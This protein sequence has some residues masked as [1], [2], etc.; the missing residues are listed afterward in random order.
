MDLRN[1]LKLPAAFRCTVTPH[2]LFPKEV[3]QGVADAGASAFCAHP[4]PPDPPGQSPLFP[5]WQRGIE[6]DAEG[7]RP[8]HT[9]FPVIPAKA[10]IQNVS[11]VAEIDPLRT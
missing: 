11:L 9:P 5:L 6:N 8:L 1:T 7:L 2:S 10:G 4:R 3:S